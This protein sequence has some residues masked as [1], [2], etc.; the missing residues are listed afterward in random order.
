M[1]YNNYV[2][3]SI[4]L[5]GED[6]DD[7]FM[8][9]VYYINQFENHSNKKTNIVP[10]LELQ[11]VVTEFPAIPPIKKQSSNDTTLN[12]NAAL[13]ESNENINYN[14]SFFSFNQNQQKEQKKEISPKSIEI[15]NEYISKEKKIENN[16]NIINNN[17]IKKEN[18][19]KI[20]KIKIK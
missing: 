20:K 6:E 13:D 5:F 18:I 12:T 7:I 11:R 4:N 3:Q 16:K 2:K 10:K 8:N 14:I 17:I 15:L 1:A 19:K 9:P